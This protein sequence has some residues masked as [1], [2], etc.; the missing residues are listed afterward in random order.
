MTKDI[1]E[2]H[3]LPFLQTN[4][5]IYNKQNKIVKSGKLIIFNMHEY[6]I[7]FVF[8]KKNGNFTFE[9]PYPF[10]VY[11]ETTKVIK[12]DYRLDTLS[13]ND[14]LLKYKFILNQPQKKNKFYDTILTIKH[15]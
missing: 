11:N 12:L 15:L 7:H 6:T 4:I 9:L 2:S 8:A 5:G 3:F 1:I 14:T 13:N 10:M